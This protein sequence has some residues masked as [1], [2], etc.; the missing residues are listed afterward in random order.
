MSE[1]VCVFV[2]ACVCVCV[3]VWWAEGYVCVW[4]GGGG[5]G[6]GLEYAKYVSL[7][8]MF[9]WITSQFLACHCLQSTS[10]G[11]SLPTIISY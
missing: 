6:G 10:L 3:C 1:C 2:Y 11:T 7:P 4:R 9:K 5:G 8:L